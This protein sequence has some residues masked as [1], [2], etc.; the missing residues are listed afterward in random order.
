GARLPPD[1]PYPGFLFRRTTSECPGTTQTATHHAHPLAGAARW[2]AFHGL[3]HY[4]T[5][6]A[7]PV[8][9]AIFPQCGGLRYVATRSYRGAQI[10]QP[11]LPQF[12][13]SPYRGTG[14]AP[15][16]RADSV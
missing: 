14:S 12:D 11:A 7:G 8:D 10:Q 4:G 2:A 9:P 15:G 1:Y 5:G 13:L 6:P 16:R 3:W